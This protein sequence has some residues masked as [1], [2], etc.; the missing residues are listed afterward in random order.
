MC[1]L[2]VLLLGE[3]G[4]NLAQVKELS[5]GLELLRELLL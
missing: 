1:L 5:G 2:I 3:V 4:F